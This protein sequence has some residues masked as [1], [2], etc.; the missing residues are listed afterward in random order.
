MVDNLKEQVSDLNI[1]LEE[2]RLNHRDTKR[3]VELS[4]L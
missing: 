3:K 4:T 1:H 2:E